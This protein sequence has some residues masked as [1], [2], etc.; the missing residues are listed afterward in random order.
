MPEVFTTILVVD[1]QP[2]WLEEHLDRLNQHARESSLRGGAA[3][4]AIQDWM[5]CF[6][7]KAFRNDEGFER[8]LLRLS[9]NK[10]GY[11][12]KIRALKP[13]S[14]KDYEQGVLVYLS[15][16]IATS[17]I[18]TNERQVYDLAYEQ[19][20]GQNAF[21]GLLLNPEGYLVDGSRT[22]LLLIQE[23]RLTILEGGIKSITRE[24]VALS[25][26]KL[27]FE[28]KRAYLKPHELEGQ[29]FLA[30]TGVG[31]VPVRKIIGLK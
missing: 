6:N 30:G 25:A 28:I 26:K 24:Q 17:Q 14:A 1:G 29:L 21:E 7:A 23:N 16:Q 31:L 11:E 22:S 8:A 5:D 19:A 3:D 2:R 15:D 13:P 18:K 10:Q 20:R 9:I 4:V 12:I 27:G